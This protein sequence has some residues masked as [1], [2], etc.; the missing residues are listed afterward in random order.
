L[1][2]DPSMPMPALSE[3][4][5]RWIPVGTDCVTVNPGGL[6]VRD[7]TPCNARRPSRRHPDRKPWSACV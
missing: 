6:D 7:R 5:M 4:K 3:A 1:S 2:S